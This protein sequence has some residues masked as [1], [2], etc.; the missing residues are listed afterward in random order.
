MAFPT[1]AN[2][3]KTNAG[4]SA[5]ID[6]TVRIWLAFGL[7]VFVADFVVSKIHGNEQSTVIWEVSDWWWWFFHGENKSTWMAHGDVAHSSSAFSSSREIL[8]MAERTCWLH[9]FVSARFWS[10]VYTGSLVDDALAFA[11]KSH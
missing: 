11:K 4:V 5:I 3:R 2:S 1:A 8:R 6:E 9:C 10:R 7:S